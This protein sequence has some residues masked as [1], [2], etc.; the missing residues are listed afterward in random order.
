MALKLNIDYVIDFSK[1]ISNYKLRGLAQLW[2]CRNSLHYRACSSGSIV[3]FMFIFYLML[4]LFS[5]LIYIEN[6]T[7]NLNYTMPVEET[8]I[9]CGTLGRLWKC[10]YLTNDTAKTGRA[11]RSPTGSKKNMWW[12]YREELLSGLW[13]WNILR[14]TA[15]GRSRQAANI[16]KAQAETYKR[17]MVF[18][19]KYLAI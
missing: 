10:D 11:W 15:S 12:S 1:K 18:V 7:I 3:L 13:H 8:V 6:R 5:S 9:V 17:C 2:F 14:S 16:N 19:T 4:I